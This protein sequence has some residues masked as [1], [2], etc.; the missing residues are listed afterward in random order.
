MTVLFHLKQKRTDKVIK[1]FDSAIHSNRFLLV[2]ASLPAAAEST[3]RNG[4]RHSKQIDELGYDPKCVCV[5]FQIM[6]QQDSSK[7]ATD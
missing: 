5:L 7:N 4:N 3:T 2:I 6:S 1:Q